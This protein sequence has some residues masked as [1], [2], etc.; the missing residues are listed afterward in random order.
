[1][2]YVQTKIA[3][4]Y[5]RK[6]LVKI[7]PRLFGG[8]TIFCDPCQS[9]HAPNQPIKRKIYVEVNQLREWSF[10]AHSQPRTRIYMPDRPWCRGI[11]GRRMCTI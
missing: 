5:P 8:P 4:K 9:K 10:S 1:M 7:D 11:D 6:I 2:D 3:D